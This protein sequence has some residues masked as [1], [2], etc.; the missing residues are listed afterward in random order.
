MNLTAKNN[1]EQFNQ[2]LFEEIDLNMYQHKFLKDYVDKAT[3]GMKPLY[4]LSV[5]N[6]SENNGWI[7]ILHGEVLLVYGE[8]WN[9]TQIKEI[10]EV[11]DL[12]KYTNYAL[13]GDNEIIDKLIEFYKPKN[14]EVEKRRVLYQTTNIKRFDAEGLKIRLGSFDQLNELAVMLQEYYH[15]E[16]DGQNDKTIEEMRQRIISVIQTENIYVLLDKNET[17]LSF[18]TIIDPDIGILF[19]KREHRRNGYGKIILSYCSQLL[20]QKNDTVYV[21]TDRDKPESNIVCEA[22]GFKP[23]FNYTMTNINCG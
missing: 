19:T 10:N 23:Y 13:G 1:T 2:F 16:Y 6:I 15:E 8:N 5:L 17:L 22:V 11:F 21:M 14:S 9:E 20:Q 12:N 3:K 4:D 7:L 18:C